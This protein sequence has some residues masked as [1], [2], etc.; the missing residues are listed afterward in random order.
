MSLLTYLSGREPSI[1]LCSPQEREVSIEKNQ[2]I[3]KF[4]KEYNEDN[5]GFKT[6][7]EYLTFK[8]YDEPE[9]IYRRHY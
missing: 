5:R 3:S 2:R 7:Q 9:P 4:V 1:K 8:E 6:L